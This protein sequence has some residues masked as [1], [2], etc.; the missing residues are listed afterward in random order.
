MSVT[1]DDEIVAWIRANAAEDGHELNA[2]AA[3]FGIRPERMRD[4]LRRLVDRGV[5]VQSSQ[6]T[7]F[8]DANP[9]YSLPAGGGVR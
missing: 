6:I 2:L 3:Q 7:G 4:R 8:S 5:L 9:S 1:S